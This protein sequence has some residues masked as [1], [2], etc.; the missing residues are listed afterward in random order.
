[1]TEQTNP[2]PTRADGRAELADDAV[3]DE[4]NEAAA[5]TDAQRAVDHAVAVLE[6]IDSGVVKRLLG[7]V[8]G[9]ARRSGRP[10]S[11]R[12]DEALKTLVPSIEAEARTVIRNAEAL[13]QPGD[14][15]GP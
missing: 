9:L 4:T 12:V 7:N 1:M 10:L 3:Q 2:D 15:P 14:V 11:K 6:D 8:T 13:S 5:R